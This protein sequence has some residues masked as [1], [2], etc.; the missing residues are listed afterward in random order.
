VADDARMQRRLRRVAGWLGSGANLRVVVAGLVAL[1]LFG[2]VVD[3]ASH[4][5]LLGGLA[6]ILARV[7]WIAGLLAIPYFALRAGTWY[8]LLDQVE[9]RAPLR[10]TIAAFCPGEL[11]KSLPGGAYLETYVLARIERLSE[12]EVVAAAVATTGLDVMIGTVTF[13][14]AMAT[15]LPG[16][17]WFRLLLVSIAGAWLVIFALVFIGVRWWRPQQRSTAPGWAQ[18]FG[19]ILVELGKSAAQLVQP[20]VIRPLATTAAALAI[21]AIVLWLVLA[22]LGLERVGMGAAV[23]V[24]AITS[25]ANALLPIPIELGLTEIAGVGVLGAWGVAAPD[26]ATVMLGYRVVTTGA[27]TLVVLAVMAILRDAFA[28]RNPNAVNPP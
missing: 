10:R 4:G 24:V 20:A 5:D 2:Y 26:A 21:Y 7:G 17:G 22:A 15:G 28:A 6:T 8:L 3:I 14:T 12:R 18:T 23:S 13:L 1:A 27:L 9:V 16:R 25:L 19:R 11:T